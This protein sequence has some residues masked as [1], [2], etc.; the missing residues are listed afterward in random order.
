[1]IWLGLV[2]FLVAVVVWISLSHLRVHLFFSRVKDNDHFFAEFKVLGGLITRRLE[3]PFVEYRGIFGGILVKMVNKGAM[4][5]QRDHL[6]DVQKQ[7]YTPE[8]ISDMYRW[9]KRLLKHV[10]EFTEWLR[11]M[12]THVKCSEFR[13]DTRL[14]IGDAAET[15]LATG[16]LWAVKSTLFG[17]IFQYVHL[18]T[19]PKLSIQPRYNH[20]EF[21]TEFSC[22]ANIRIGFLFYSMLVLVWRI[23][24]SKDGFK[25]WLTIFRRA[26]VQKA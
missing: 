6:K 26:R 1:M 13:W 25:T 9:G 24:K 5:A 22:H 12:L 23:M 10:K 4:G 21:S 2:L 8:R 16:M 14:G 7:Q 20:P 18:E 19:K 11:H 3:V 17:Y 15:A